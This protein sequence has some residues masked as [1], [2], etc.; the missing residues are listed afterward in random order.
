MRIVLDTNIVISGIFWGG[1]PRRVLDAARSGRIELFTSPILLAELYEV[2]ERTKFADRLRQVG[3]SAE[4]LVRDYQQLAV[5]V[6]DREFDLPVVRD[7]DDTVVLACA[8][9][10]NAVAIVSGD[11]DLLELESASGVTILT[12]TQ[13]LELL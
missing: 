4:Q 6:R 7:V 13:L 3:V 5:T 9:E 8:L 10:A 1:P 11:L 12:A 2:L